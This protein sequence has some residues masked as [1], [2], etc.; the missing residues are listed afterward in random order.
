MTDQS[1]AKLPSEQNLSPLYF[2]TVSLW[3][4]YRFL[5][6]STDFSS[7]SSPLKNYFFKF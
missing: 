5:A 6:L 2:S 1:D 4:P 7:K 3:M